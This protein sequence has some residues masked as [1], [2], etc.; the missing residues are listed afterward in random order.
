MDEYLFNLLTVEKVAEILT[1]KRNTIHNRKWQER[2]GCKFRKIGKR[3]YIEAEQ[4]WK[5][6]RSN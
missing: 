6:F 4:F 2:T 1:I 5:W 3:N